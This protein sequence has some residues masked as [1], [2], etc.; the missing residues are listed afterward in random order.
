MG[1][2]PEATLDEWAEK[3][4]EKLDR[5]V[6]I[7]TN[8]MELR[9]DVHA[10]VLEAASELFGLTD[11]STSG[12]RP[13]GGAERRAYDRAYG[14]LIVEWEW[15]M[16]T[17]RR[18]HAADQALDYLDRR[19]AAVGDDEVFSAVVCDGREWGFLVV[20]LPA[21]QLALDE[22]ADLPPEER[23]EWRP[24]SAA[25]CRRFLSLIGS[26]RKRPVTPGALAAEFGPGSATTR[27]S[28][29]LLVEALAGRSPDDRSDTLFREWCRSLEVVYDNFG[30]SDGEL[31]DALR[32]AYGIQSARPLSEL[33]YCVH[34][35]FA[36]IARL[37]A[38]EVLA[39]S[40]HD[41][42]AQPSLWP[43]LDDTELDGRLRS[44]DLGAV[45]AGLRIQNL[46][47]G[48]LFSW[49]RDSLLGNS[50]LLSSIRDVLD[51]IGQFAFPRLAFGA[52][53]ARDV[54]RDLYQDLLPRELRKALGEFL[55]PVWLAE[56]CIERLRL[57]GA[58]IADGRT[59]DPTCGTGTFLIPILNRRLARVRA[60]VQGEPSREDVQAALDAVV[61]FDLNPVAVVAARV[62]YL[63][64]LGD[65]ASVGELTLPI[66]RADSVLV[67]DA[68]TVQTD[69]T[70]PTLIGRPWQALK[71]S[72]DDPFPVPPALANAHAMPVLR[73]A[74]EEALEEGDALRAHAAFE[75]SIEREFGP[76]SAQ[77]CVAP[78][79]W[80]DVRAVAVELFDRIWLL[81]E[82]ERN[83]VWARLIENSF[84]PLFVGEFDVVLGN[85]PWL[86][87]NRLP[88]SWRAAG[89]LHWRRYGL[90][91][92]PAEPGEA[93]PP[94][95]Q[96]GDVATLVYATALARYARDGGFVGLLVPRALLI[97]DPG[98]RAFRQYKLA[99]SADDVGVVGERD[100]VTFAC[101]YLDDWSALNPFSP[102]ASN[103]PVFLITQRAAG[104]Q[105]FPVPTSRWERGSRGARLGGDWHRT[106]FVLREIQGSS[107][108]VDA[109]VETSAWSFAPAGTVLLEG[110]S[111]PWSFGLGLNTRGANG[112]FFVRV[113]S[114]R[115]DK[116]GTVEIV[117][118]PTAG[119][120]RAV[121]AR[122]GRV[123]SSLV[124][125]LLR[126]REVSRWVARPEAHIIVPYEQE[127]MGEVIIQRTFQRAYPLAYRWLR[128]FRPILT[129]RSV[130]ATLGWNLEG[131]D[132]AQVMGPMEFM[133]GRPMVAVREI[134]EAPAAA[135]VLPAYDARLGR[136][137]TTL[138]DHKLLFCGVA[139][140]D[141]A[142]YVA[143]MINSGPFQALLQ[144][145]ASSTG[146]T[147]RA[148][149]RLPIPA[150]DPL[151]HGSVVNAARDARAAAM[152][153]N[154]AAQ[155]A[156]E[157]A[158][159]AAVAL[160][161]P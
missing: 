81:A 92:P 42:D 10:L 77:P 108:R 3:L 17:A 52:N 104:S 129:Q 154:R 68:P 123:E 102:E 28:V 118:D 85:P 136:T 121:Q 76:A 156:A 111:N 131:D 113:L 127:T 4:A 50:D 115:P 114:S 14:G 151:A 15:A 98:G 48:D 27:K 23:F 33:L 64:A 110:G 13:A 147:P 59:L 106:R 112:I 75:V 26:N 83:G 135:V 31:A 119:R 37:V 32:S 103:N 125:P 105:S 49:Y 100:S 138:I 16:G 153:S 96:I 56:A 158:V 43:S 24:N 62:N 45:P 149:G 22:D 72:L 40:V 19:R 128:A 148:L 107:L 9:E 159:E 146:V 1:A 143:G 124:Y 63:V 126:G 144:S 55:T 20:D 91:R 36:L 94:N 150:F 11:L 152:I 41:R 97:G 8:E 12:E 93:R 38:I 57:V 18:R 90:W 79:D 78:A 140:E 132:F 130:V 60:A 116:A 89:E 29:I 73:R 5:S 2:R 61:G 122:R 157:A 161:L 109:A 30:D 47:E 82:T 133:D 84:A 53:P 99:P 25:A 87:W 155:S 6:A 58:P 69:T 39:H 44:I 21:G 145:F 95:P 70:Y 142:H 54:L 120:N 46:F 86:A 7:R 34:T 67:P 74:I 35:Y 88:A 101:R 80:D 71:T 139:D 51:Q 137:A 66:W 65:L 141:E 160:L 117:N 134:S